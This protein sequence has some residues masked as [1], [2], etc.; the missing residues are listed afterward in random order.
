[1]KYPPTEV[2]DPNEEESHEVSFK[3]LDNIFD[4]TY[5]NTITH[6]TPSPPTQY[7]I[8][9]VHFELIDWNQQEPLVLD[10]CANDN[11]LL[12]LLTMQDIQDHISINRIQLN[13]EAYFVIQVNS[14]CHKNENNKKNQKSLSENL[15]EETLDSEKAKIKD[16]SSSENLD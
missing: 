8:Q 7:K 12:E 13:W 2:K 14:L 1:M 15:P 10:I 4:D 11:A 6:V 3:Y 5:I 16:T 9:L